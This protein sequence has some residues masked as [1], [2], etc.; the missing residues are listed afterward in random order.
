MENYFEKVCCIALGKVFG[1]E[2]RLPLALIQQ[3]GS[4][5]AVIGLGENGIDDLL[6]P[7][8]KIKEHFRKIDLDDAAKELDSLEKYGSRYIAIT[9]AGFPA[10]LKE[11]DDP[12]VG[13]YV[14]SS[15]PPEEVFSDDRKFISV[16]GTRSMSSYGQEWCNRIV[17]ALAM[18]GNK[19]TI[20]SGL[21]YGVDITAHT[22][23]L[24]CG[25]ATIACMA[26]GVESIY[27]W[28]HIPFADRIKDAT[29][30]ALVTDFPLGS[31]PLRSSFLRRNRIIAGL[32]EAT[33]LI[34]SKARG[35][36]M[37]TSDLAFS[38]GR[39]VYALP[40][41]A[42]DIYS[43]GCNRLIRARVAEPVYDETLLLES[44][45]LKDRRSLK[46]STFNAVEIV[47]EKYSKSKS[48]QEMEKLAAI[49][50]IVRKRRDISIEEIGKLCALSYREA[51]VHTA[52]LESDSLISIDLLGRCSIA[53]H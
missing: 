44:L 2:P 1:S 3:F 37:V 35:G 9:E 17:E 14:R 4:A 32:S 38:Y 47:S 30:S 27:P 40:G 51:S 45:G 29:G 16:V 28:R 46:R 39:E 10:A 20:V 18:S 31:S 24:D 23:A 48:A 13:L 6:G 26:T 50:D 22:K 53:F 25:I 12:P 36:G 11:C 19:I 7:F 49:L 34:E 21:A 52:L 5:S 42:D 33:I 8:S 43:A 41:R 15:S